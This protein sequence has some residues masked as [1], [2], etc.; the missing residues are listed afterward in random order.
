V[1]GVT[2]HHATVKAELLWQAQASW[3]NWDDQT[4]WCTGGNGMHDRNPG[5]V[6]A[7]WLTRLLFAYDY[8]GRSAFT[9]GEL[10]TL[11]T[12]FW[13]AANFW[14][15][16]ADNDM[17]GIFPNRLSDSDSGASACS[18]DTGCSATTL[19]SLYTGGPVAQGIQAFT[20]NRRGSLWRFVALVGLYL[21][22]HGFTPA[23]SR[24]DDGGATLT[25]LITSGRLFV[26]EFIRHALFPDGSMNEFC[27][28]DQTNLPD[29]GWH[30]AGSTLGQA[31]TIA[32]TLARLG[33]TS[34]YTYSTAAGICSATSGSTVGTI[35]DGGS[36]VGQNRDLLF[37]IQAYAKYPSD[38]YTRY[39]GTSGDANKRIDGRHPRTSSSWSS[40][41]DTHVAP[42]N[43]YFQ[44]TGVQ[45]VYRRLQA[46]TV[47]Y[48]VA[49]PTGTGQEPWMGE[50]SI[51]PGV[52]F[53]TGQLEGVVHPYSLTGGS[54]TPPR[55]R[56]VR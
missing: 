2:T 7:S 4:H 50:N 39:A 16:D 8:L 6:I 47:A 5:F 45:Q 51:Y 27:R 55:L 22:D 43:L 54:G 40:I 42:G 52:L 36:R 13:N 28:A 49:P 48:P 25:T 24:T 17:L 29:L 53:M 18:A 32:D 46:G 38:G 56:L 41:N 12:W 21:S 20:N 33:D 26:K 31:L 14:R 44:D 9:S 3:A 35:N 10:T 1:L 37:A 23:S 34:L 11:D 19:G 30:Y 15:I